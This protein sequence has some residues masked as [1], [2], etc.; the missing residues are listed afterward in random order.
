MSEVHPSKQP[1]QPMPEQPPAER[2]TNFNEVPLGYTPEQAMAEAARCLQCKNPRCVTGCPVAVDIPGFIGL[3]KE[4]QFVEA[5]RKIMETNVLPAV[6]GRVCPQETQCE[7]LCVLARRGEPVAIGRL[8]RFVADYEREHGP[9]ET[10]PPV[11]ATGK[12]VA[13]VGSGPAGLTCA[14]DLARRGHSV[15]VFEALHELG[16]VLVY[17]IPEFRLPKRI[18]KAEVERLRDLGVDLQTSAVIGKLDTIEELLGPE[19]FDAVF[20]ATGAGLPKFMD[21]PGENLLGVYS[22]NEFLTRSNLMRAYEFGKADTP[23]ARG[24][25]VMVIGGGNV[26]M[27]AARTAKRLGAERVILAYRR[28]REEMPARA[29]EIHHA[30]EEGIEFHLLTLPVK[31]VGDEQGRLV[32][33]VLRKMEL[34]EPDESGRRRPLEIPGSDYESP[35]DV[36]VVAS[37]AGA[38]PLIKDTTPGLEVNKW[39]YIVADKATGATSIPGVYAGGDIVTG[40]ATV[41]EAMGAGRTAAA[42][43]HLYLT[44][45]APERDGAS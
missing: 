12:R 9:R 10:V 3:T 32:G 20:V 19:G 6:C 38:N 11:P 16:G 13:I 30:E 4:G 27:D 28:S 2:V 43:I 21:I 25:R 36:V 14:A 44:G 42:A 7:I 23:I 26:A 31:L 39:G 34:G 8:E 24:K 18:L 1:R 37:V 17:G 40:S 5:A 35:V 41:I 33:A 29:E 45:E 22:A 15:T